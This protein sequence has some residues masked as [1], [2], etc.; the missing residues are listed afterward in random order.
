[1]M[2][3]LH[4]ESGNVRGFLG[5]LG[6]VL[7]AHIL[8]LALLAQASPEVRKAIA[9]IVV[10]L[11]TPPQPLPQSPPLPSPPS[12]PR[13]KPAV[14]QVAP[15][16][17]SEPLA[18]AITIETPPQ[19]PAPASDASATPVAMTTPPASP[20]PLTPPRF[21]A[22][23]LRNPAPAY[24]ILSRR[25]GEQGRV[26]LRV[27]VS[28]AGLPEEVEVRQSSGSLHL[29]QAAQE[30]VSKWRFVP[31]RR[32]EGAVGAWVIVPISFTLEG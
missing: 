9:P 14:Q 24:P 25:L 23:Y 29:D 3:R 12:K 19:P 22:A 15:P 8:L 6:A 7:A 32:G 11:I 27:F 20:A 18:N 10:S 31:A 16:P 1:M 28:S 4:G 5:R 30:A 13:P 17:A 26:L 21:D 2:T